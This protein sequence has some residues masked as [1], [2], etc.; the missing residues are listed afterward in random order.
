MPDC[1]GVRSAQRTVKYL[2]SCNRD[3]LIRAPIRQASIFS[4]V[5]DRMHA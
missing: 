4:R 1:H 2:L 3:V 5:D